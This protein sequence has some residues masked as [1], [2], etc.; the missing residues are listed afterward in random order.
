MQMRTGKFIETALAISIIATVSP[1]FSAE[2]EEGQSQVPPSQGMNQNEG[3]GKVITSTITDSTPLTVISMAGFKIEV[4][5]LDK[6]AT[7]EDLKKY[8]AQKWN[9][10]YNTNWTEENV[11]LFGSDTVVG[12]TTGNVIKY[13]NE[14]R[15]SIEAIHKSKD[16]RINV[17]I[18]RPKSSDTSREEGQA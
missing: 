6:D 8:V 14:D 4:P 16:R 7:I 13:K 3:Q 17:T 10:K 9:E 5:Y 1:I 2:S 11:H 18:I 12:G 15:I